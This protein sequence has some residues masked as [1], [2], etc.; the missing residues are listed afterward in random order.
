MLYVVIPPTL[1]AVVLVALRE[2]RGGTTT[3]R[4]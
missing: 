4:R 1:V 2:I 3:P